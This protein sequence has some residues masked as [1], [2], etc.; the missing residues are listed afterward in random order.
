MAFSKEKEQC[1][2]PSDEVV[3]HGEEGRKEVR[4][5]GEGYG[6]G[7]LGGGQRMGVLMRE[8]EREGGEAPGAAATTIEALPPARLPYL[9]SFLAFP[10]LI[11]EPSDHRSPGEDDLIAVHVACLISAALLLGAFSLLGCGTVETASE[12][13]PGNLGCLRGYFPSA[14]STLR[15][16]NRAIA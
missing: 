16:Q 5:E 4:K 15:S 10:A 9:R 12:V 13:R 11:L 7:G 2:A 3:S 6:R 14:L 8:R 1:H